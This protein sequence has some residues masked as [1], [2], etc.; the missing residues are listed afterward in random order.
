MN[1]KFAPFKW[2][3]Q[4]A[5]SLSFVDNDFDYAFVSDGLHHCSSPHKALL[6]MY[7]VARDSLLLK[8][9]QK[10][11]LSQS[12]ELSA[13]INHGFEYGGVDN[14]EIPNFIYRWTEREFKKTIQSFNPTGKHNFLFFYDL[15]LPLWST[16]LKRKELHFYIVKLTSPIVR[17]FT[18]LFKKQCNS[19]S[20]IAL[21]PSIPSDL[22]PWL[23]SKNGRIVFNRDYALKN[24]KKDL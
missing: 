20:M 5:Q 22:W 19:F 17:L 4:D 2:S 13:V 7:C 15:N 11:N 1:N 3:Y 24:F 14:S 6:E 16:S 12:Y 21:K 10:M 9:A 8:I 18:R 23:K